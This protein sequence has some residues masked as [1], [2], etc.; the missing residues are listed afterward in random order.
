[1]VPIISKEQL[2]TNTSIS[3]F[4]PEIVFLLFSWGF[5]VTRTQ[6]EGNDNLSSLLHKVSYV[7]KR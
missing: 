2:I 6:K 1:M 5:W 3:Q 4:D 7:L